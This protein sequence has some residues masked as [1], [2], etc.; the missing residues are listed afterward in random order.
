MRYNIDAYHVQ[1]VNVLKLEGWG[2]GREPEAH[3]GV[4]KNRRISFSQT[5]LRNSYSIENC[6]LFPVPFYSQCQLILG[7]I[8][9]KREVNKIPGTL[10]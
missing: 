1:W 10:L 9:G 2:W 4:D 6:F 5:Y 8:V 7:R 3:E